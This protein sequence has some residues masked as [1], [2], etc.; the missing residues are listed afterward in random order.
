M[1]ITNALQ[2]TPSPM[3]VSPNG[4]T[5]FVPINDALSGGLPTDFNRLRNDFGNF[6]VRN[7]L[8]LDNLRS[9]SGSNISS[10]LTTANLPRLHLRVVRNFYRRT[11]N[12]TLTPSVSTSSSSSP[13]SSAINANT[14]S[15]YNQ[16]VNMYGLAAEQYNGPAIS[17]K[18]PQDE[19]YLLNDAILLDYFVCSNG[20]V[21]LMNSYPRYYDMSVY[22]LLTSGTIPTL[23][24]NTK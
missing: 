4:F 14:S 9:M 16:F 12:S 3:Y 21:Y 5:V 11:L 13:Q 7:Y 6:V 8:T 19:L 1:S 20:I 2:G 22:Q 10:T 15:I 24:Q 17:I 23:T 18:F